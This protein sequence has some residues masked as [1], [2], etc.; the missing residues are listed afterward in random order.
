MKSGVEMIAD[1]RR[2]QVSKE[3]Y[4]SFHDD[5]HTRGAIARAAAV[6]ATPPES[7]TRVRGMWPRGW[8]FKASPD[9][10]IRELVKAG[11]MIAAEIDRLSRQKVGK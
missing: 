10:R 7:R 11:A 6:Y 8:V 3:K 9:D 2:R 4:S 1:E 5:T